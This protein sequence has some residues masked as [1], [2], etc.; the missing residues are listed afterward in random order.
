MEKV[1]Q[2]QRVTF[3]S[4]KWPSQS[5]RRP[6][7]ARK[8]LPNPVNDLRKREKVFRIQ[9]TTFSSQKGRFYPKT[10]SGKAVNPTDGLPVFKK[11]QFQPFSDRPGDSAFAGGG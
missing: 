2:I 8:G 10:S 5:S 6:S 7:D 1:F 4:A 9:R 11:R 3:G